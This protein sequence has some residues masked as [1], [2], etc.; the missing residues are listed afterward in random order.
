MSSTALHDKLA[1]AGATMAVFDATETPASFGDPAAELAALR[2]TCGL[3]DLGRRGFLI[4]TGNDRVRWLNGMVT[5][6]VRDLAPGNGNYSFVLNPQGRIQGD[7]NT[8]NRGEYLMVTTDRAQLPKLKELFDRYI[9]M[10]DVEVTDASDKL[11]SIAVTG[12][13][14]HEILQR[15]GFTL[16]AMSPGEVLDTEWHGI[17]LSLVRGIF[18]SIQTYELWLTHDNAPAAWDAL[19][20]AGAVPVGTE[21][22]EFFRILHGIP[23]YGQDIGERDLPQETAQSHALHFS[24]GCYIGQEI[25]ERIHS[26]GNVHRTFAGFDLGH[27]APPEKGSKAQRDGKDVGEITTAAVLPLDTPRTLAIGYLRREAATPGSEVQIGNTSAQ[28]AHLPFQL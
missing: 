19:V 18:D 8:Y 17:G 2:R 3:Y 5:N 12:P 28:V 13:I 10:D 11:T 26:R 1:A 9:I 6:N 4:L 20:S 16:P 14:A 22:I 15:A 21:A 25:V 7:L 27:G 23:R 24:K